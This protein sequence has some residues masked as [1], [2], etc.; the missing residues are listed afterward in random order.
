M[1]IEAE[2]MLAVEDFNFEKVKRLVAK[3]D[4]KKVQNSVGDTLLHYATGRLSRAKKVIPIPRSL[5][6]KQWLEFFL[7]LG[8]TKGE[9]ALSIDVMGGR[10]GFTPLHLAVRDGYIESIDILLREGASLTKTNKHGHNALHI[11]ALHANLSCIEFLISK[12]ALINEKTDD[13]LKETALHLAVRRQP[14]KKVDRSE[15]VKC[16]KILLDD[17][18]GLIHVTDA[19]GCTPLHIAVKASYPEFV[20]LLIERGAG[21]C[22]NTKNLAGE[23]PVDL[24]YQQNHKE[25]ISLL[26][27]NPALPNINSVLKRKRDSNIELP[28]IKIDPNPV[29][30][31]CSETSTIQNTLIGNYPAL[32]QPKKP[33]YTNDCPP[34]LENTHSF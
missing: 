16:I 12:G 10:A 20:K 2:L 3:V 14:I 13:A 25:I 26:L 23:S 27:P 17:E 21:A 11:A 33:K 22:I 34:H 1:S 18:G 9:G 31:G 4:I 7:N 29:E 15:H 30:E 6:S 28:P 8:I 32:F 24:A 19:N 5:A